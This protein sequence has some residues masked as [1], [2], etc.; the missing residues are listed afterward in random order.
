MGRCWIDR[1]ISSQRDDGQ[2][3][4]PLSVTGVGG[5]HIFPPDRDVDDHVY[6]SYEFPAAGYYDDFQ[7]RRLADANKKIVVTYSSI[8][9]NGFGGYGETVLGTKGTILLEREKDVMLYAGSN[10]T[11][12]VNVDQ[13]QNA[14]VD[15]YETGGGA[16]AVAQTAISEDV[17]RG[18]REEIE[19]WAWCIRNP[20]PENQ[21]KCQPKV[22]LADAVIALT[23]NIA[24]A[25]KQRIE[26]QSEW[27]QIDRDETPEGV[28]PRSADQV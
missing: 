23:S 25:K 13:K 26:F 16:A 24:I 11:T 12:R 3:V 17:S 9:G 8:N 5:R 22:A 21:P 7:S 14:L 15:T 6:C 20:A 18:Y 27:F 10:T 1:A 4:L 2:K 28:K 19:H